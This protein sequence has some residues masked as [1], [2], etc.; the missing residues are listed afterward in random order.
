MSIFETPMPVTLSLSKGRAGRSLP[1][2]I[3]QATYHVFGFT[4]I[5]GF[6]RRSRLA[7][8]TLRWPTLSPAYAA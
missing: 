4:Q 7:P 6:E 3:R 2:M 8:A 1:A 5:F